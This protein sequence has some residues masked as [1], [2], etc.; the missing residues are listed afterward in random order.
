MH[1]TTYNLCIVLLL[2]LGSN[3]VQAQQFRMGNKE[4][5]F[6]LPN[7]LWHEAKVDSNMKINMHRT[8]FK[9]EAVEVAN[10]VLVIPNIE[11]VIEKT[12]Y[13]L[14]SFSGMKQSAIKIKID[15]NLYLKNGKLMLAGSKG[16]FGHYVR[17]NTMYKMCIIHCV[18]NGYGAQIILDCTADVFDEVWVEFRYFVESL[19][20]E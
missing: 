3:L 16:Y 5:T 15:S 8:V 9:R 18:Y 17:N 20:L 2:I 6:E 13:S 12:P 7:H 1:K 4:L 11:I 19:K 14:S 10:R